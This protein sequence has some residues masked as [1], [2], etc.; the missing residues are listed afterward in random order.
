MQK[1]LTFAGLVSSA[2]AHATFLGGDGV[3]GHQF[4][5]SDLKSGNFTVANVNMIPPHKWDSWAPGS[6]AI[7]TVE[8][9]TKKKI[10]AGTFKWQIYETGVTS[11]IASGNAPYFNCDNKGCDPASPVALKWK[12]GTIGDF[13]L[14]LQAALPPSRDARIIKVIVDVGGSAFRTDRYLFR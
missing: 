1:L 5:V 7:V 10:L 3:Q 13:T 4:T 2:S 14:T 9:T 6:T 12:S 8:G 11:F